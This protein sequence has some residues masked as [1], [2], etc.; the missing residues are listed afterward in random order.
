[1]Q[2]LL[3]D[4]ANR[5]ALVAGADRRLRAWDLAAGAPVATYAGHGD[6]VCALGFLPDKAR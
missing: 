5:L 3:V 1:M 2:A 4:A 6:C